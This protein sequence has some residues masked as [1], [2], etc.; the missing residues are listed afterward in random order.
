[1][2]QTLFPLLQIVFLSQLAIALKVFDSPPQFVHLF[3]DDMW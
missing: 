3:A 1:M 2:R